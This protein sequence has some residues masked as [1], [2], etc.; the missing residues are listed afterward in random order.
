MCTFEIIGE[1]FLVI[2]VKNAIVVILFLSFLA[3]TGG[4][5]IF[6]QF[7]RRVVRKEVK[8]KMMAG[9]PK[10]DLVLLV[11]TKKEINTKLSW[12]HAKEFEFEGNMY[13]IVYEEVIGDKKHYWCWLDTEETKLNKELDYLA[14]NLFN[15]NPDNNQKQKILFSFYKTLYFS[16]S[17]KLK[18]AVLTEHFSHSFFYSKNFSSIT[19]PPLLGPPK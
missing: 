6:L 15:Q 4:T 7:Q 14:C 3:P 10:A 11:F 8:K 18:L 2:T 13:D 19:L 9:I 1:L 17:Q 5:F 12:E 16:K